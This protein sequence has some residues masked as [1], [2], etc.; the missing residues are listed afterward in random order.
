MLVGEVV[1]SDPARVTQYV[2][3]DELHMAFNFTLLL[4]PLE[5]ERRVR[6]RPLPRGARGRRRA[7]DV[8]A[9]EPRRAAHRDALREHRGRAR[10][11]SAPARAARPAFLY[12]GQELGLEEVDLPGCGAPGSGVP[13]HNG[14]RKGRDGCR[15]PIPWDRDAPSF[16]FTTG[17]PWLPMPGSWGAVSVEAQRGD[18]GSTLAL[19]RRALE[20]RRELEGA[21]LKWCESPPGTLMFERGA[22]SAR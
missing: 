22:T 13:P 12:Q 10:R 18:E 4:E 17:E 6:D 2:R 21:P 7:A 3:D 14:A 9:R 8:G 15:V 1:F 20:L 5:A 19:Y 16:G 11:G